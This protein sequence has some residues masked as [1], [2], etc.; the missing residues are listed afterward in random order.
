MIKSLIGN[1]LYITKSR[2]SCLLAVEGGRALLVVN[3]TV[4]ESRL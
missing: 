4:E 2:Y 3:A 1:K